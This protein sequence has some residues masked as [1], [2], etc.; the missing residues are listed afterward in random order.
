MKPGRLTAAALAA[1]AVIIL[2]AATLWVANAQAR[3]APVIACRLGPEVALYSSLGRLPEA[4]AGKR[5]G[6]AGYGG[7]ALRD[8]D[9]NGTDVA[10][11]GIAGAGGSSAPAARAIDGCLWYEH[12]GYARHAQPALL[13][14]AA[15][16]KAPLLLATMMAWNRLS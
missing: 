12:G 14:L 7:L 11:L 5:A 3:R 16:A 10:D 9:L 4:I 13:D 8:G 2:T 6:P 15:D 1:L